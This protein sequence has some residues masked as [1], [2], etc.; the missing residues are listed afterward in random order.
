MRVRSVSLWPNRASLD[1]TD[2]LA[3]HDANSDVAMITP[4]WAPGVSND[5]ELSSILYTITYSCNSMIEICSTK[6][7]TQYTTCIICE[8]NRVSFNS[9]S[10]W[11]LGDCCLELSWI[12][13]KY[14][15]PSGNANFTLCRIL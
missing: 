13:I 3:F 14:V 5:V 12:V 10:D 15:P 8:D 1:S 11:P 6:W 7:R 4:V 9:H 2:A